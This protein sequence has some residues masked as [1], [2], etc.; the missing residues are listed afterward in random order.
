MINMQNGWRDIENRSVK[1]HKPLSVAYI[2]AHCDERAGHIIAIGEIML[3]DYRSRTAVVHVHMRVLLKLAKRFDSV[4]GNN[5]E[6]CL[7]IHVLQNRSQY[8]IQR[9]VLIRKRIYPN[10]V[11]FWIVTFVKRLN[12]IQP[13][14]NTVFTG[15][16]HHGEIRR[17]LG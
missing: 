5:E 12:R 7:V 11:D 6:I 15:L 3:G 9:D 2:R 10:A 13:M 14:S 1:T 8:L 16:R 4:I 17:M